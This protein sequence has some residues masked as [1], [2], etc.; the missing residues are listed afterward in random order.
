[1]SVVKYR[2]S[3]TDEWQDLSIIKG[4]KGDTGPVGP[5]GPEGPV[6][7]QGPKGDTGP[8]GLQGP[9]GPQGIQGEQ[10]PKGDGAYPEGAILN[11]W[12][13][14]NGTQPVWSTLYSNN[15]AWTNST[16]GLNQALINIDEDL[17]FMNN[18]ILVNKN[19]EYAYGTGRYAVI[20]ATDRD[21]EDEALLTAILSQLRGY[22]TAMVILFWDRETSNINNRLVSFSSSTGQL[23]NYPI[24]LE[25]NHIYQFIS[26]DHKNESQISNSVNN[27]KYWRI[28]KTIPHCALPYMWTSTS[29]LQPGGPFI[30]CHNEWDAGTGDNNIFYVRDITD[31]M[32]IYNNV[33]SGLEALTVQQAIDELASKSGGSGSSSAPD[34][35]IFSSYT[36][37]NDNDKLLAEELFAYY[38]INGEPKQ[39]FFYA[40]NG[41]S[42]YEINS[43]RYDTTNN[44]LTYQ[45]ITNGEETGIAFYFD[46]NGKVSSANRASDYIPPKGG[47]WQWVSKT[48][49]S[50]IDVRNY[51][52]KH[53]KI[54][55]EW[56]GGP[57]ITYTLDA[58]GNYN[59]GQMAKDY[60][61]ND[62][63][64]SSTQDSLEAYLYIVD[65]NGS[66]ELYDSYG[67]SYF[68]NDF[69]VN[70]I[71]YWKE[72]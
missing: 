45:V 32:I 9:Q 38:K 29:Y 51:S 41:N 48:G 4:E 34:V 36:S 19:V 66:L 46:E 7:P 10:G 70:G 44:R 69:Y 42:L 57:V 8:Q 55:G 20:K 61:V 39:G 27:Y 43:F 59:F 3:L 62:P 5:A 47:Q 28:M 63:Y 13:K 12:L 35:Y 31:P 26:I 2:N 64:W 65:D 30:L 60:I 58:Y 67:N 15:V 53:I 52:T 22:S 11:Q 16:G 25:K 37:A 14:Y 24:T 23:Y 72:A 49:V 33:N 56:S 21:E 1:M 40:K 71:Y 17:K 6:G 54:V 18:Q 68:G 50:S